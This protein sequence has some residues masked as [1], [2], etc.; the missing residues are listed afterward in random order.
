VD[1]GIGRRRGAPERA[2]AE[3][4]SGR[5]R[6]RI[7]RVRVGGGVDAGDE[8]EDG[9]RFDRRS[10]VVLDG[11]IHAPLNSDGTAGRRV[12]TVATVHSTVDPDTVR[13]WL[14]PRAQNPAALKSSTRKVGAATRRACGV[15]TESINLN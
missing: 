6:K 15:D 9:H 3:A 14:T 4:D 12:R 5:R 1:G 13:T 10:G 8:I 7:G 2:A 11:G